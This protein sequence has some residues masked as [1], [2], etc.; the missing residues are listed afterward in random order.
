MLM[1]LSVLFR[2]CSSGRPPVAMRGVTQNLLPVCFTRGGPVLADR[3]RSTQRYNS[4][5]PERFVSLF[6]PGSPPPRCRLESGYPRSPRRRQATSCRNPW[7][8]RRTPPPRRGCPG[9][10]ARCT[11]SSCRISVHATREREGGGGGGEIAVVVMCSEQGYRQRQTDTIPRLDG[12]SL[13]VAAA[14][15]DTN[16]L[17]RGKRDE[18]RAMGRE[19]RREATDSARLNVRC[20]N[21][22]TRQIPNPRACGT[23]SIER[24][25]YQRAS[26]TVHTATRLPAEEDAF[27]V[28]AARAVATVPSAQEVRA[29]HRVG[30]DIAPF[31]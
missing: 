14:R 17:D 25:T 23:L 29:P 5:A 10:K 7:T 31:V 30:G 24:W 4:G 16:R 8:T 15:Y 12:P 3:F 20:R 9:S 28:A 13:S 19:V 26:G 2:C 27:V 21:R 18:Q 6:S 11:L 1:L 22:A